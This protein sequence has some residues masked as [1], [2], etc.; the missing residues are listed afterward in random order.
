MGELTTKFYLIRHG[1]AM[2][3]AQGR[4]QGHIDLPLSPRGEQQISFLKERFRETKFDVIYSSPLQRA[5]ATA[6]AVNFYR[7][8][9]LG[10]INGLMEINAG[11]FEGRTWEE[12]AERYPEQLALWRDRPWDFHPEEGESMKEVYSRISRTALFLAKRH[13][14]QTVALSSHGCALRNLLCWAS[15]RPVERLNEV[16]LSGNTAV[17]LIEVDSGGRPS[18]VFWNDESHLDPALR[19]T[20]KRKWMGDAKEEQAG[21]DKG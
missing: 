1:E 9:P 2:G 3:N 7:D 11:V 5:A 18:V 14:R 17:S 8:R 6:E 16:P 15:G 13:R 19:T 20:V 10:Y 12:I 21:G 4:F